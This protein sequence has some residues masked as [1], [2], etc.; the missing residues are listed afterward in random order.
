[1]NI[2]NN[3]NEFYPTPKALL[4]KITEGMKWEEIASILEPNAG[5]GDIADFVQEKCKSYRYRDEIDIDCIE[6]DDELRKTLKGKN[7]RV[8]HS[9]ILLSNY[10]A[11]KSVY[12]LVGHISSRSIAIV[13]CFKIFCAV[14]QYTCRYD[15]FGIKP[16][17]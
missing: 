1:M 10:S 5:K 3:A 4:D 15:L 2:F 8:I 9:I 6:I 14:V 12:H 16:E 17:P 11:K 7:F 13:L